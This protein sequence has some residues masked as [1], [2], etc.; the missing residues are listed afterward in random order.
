MIFAGGPGKSLE[1]G[2]YV[3]RAISDIASQSLVRAGFA[4]ATETGLET[5]LRGETTNDWRDLT[6]SEWIVGL[7]QGITEPGALK[8][9][10]SHGNTEVRVYLPGDRLSVE[11]LTGRPRFH[12]KTIS[13]ESFKHSSQRRLFIT[14]ANLTHAALGGTPSNYELG[15]AKS[16][17]DGLEPEEVKTFDTWWDSVWK[18]SKPVTDELIEQYSEIREE[19]HT[20][21]PILGEY[22]ASEHVRYASDAQCLWIETE[23]MTG[24]SRNQ[25]EFNEE[26]SRFFT[27]PSDDTNRII[28]DFN[29]RVY[30]ERPVN[31]RI[32][33]PPFGVRIRKL[34]LP[35]GFNYREKVIHLEKVLTD[36]GEK[37][38][39]R[40]TVRERGDKDVAEW[41]RL[42]EESG[43]VD[44]TGGGRAY[45][46]YK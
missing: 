15:I 26:L 19:A 40:L 3:E 4:Y 41:K 13:I 33:D 20:Q 12:A 29:G 23:K 32:T 45:G 16:V 8:N 9:L 24:G 44:E 39:Y 31:T 6:D 37:P 28:I 34:G 1:A 2:E 36:P 14:S 27:R 18:N 5:F 17:A 11:T 43:I 35:T 7:D 30:D 22:E 10:Q 46:Y 38:R 42:S 21:N 25:L